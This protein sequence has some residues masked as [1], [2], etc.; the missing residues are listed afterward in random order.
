MA[1]GDAHGGQ[2][3]LNIRQC[4]GAPAVRADSG[5]G[6]GHAVYCDLERIRVASDCDARSFAVASHGTVATDGRGISEIL[7]PLMAGYALA[8]IPIILLFIFSM[9][10]FVR[11]LTEGAVKG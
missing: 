1:T 3:R 5:D 4:H 8:S 9:K 10:L 7:G 6:W 2:Q 11:G